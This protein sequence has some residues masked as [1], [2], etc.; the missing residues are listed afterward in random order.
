MG[1]R[2]QK[3]R[4]KDRHLMRRNQS[5]QALPQGKEGTSL[6]HRVDVGRDSGKDSG[7]RRQEWC[8]LLGGGTAGKSGAGF[9]VAA[10]VRHT[11]GRFVE[12]GCKGSS[13]LRTRGWSGMALVRKLNTTNKVTCVKSQGKTLCR[14]HLHAPGTSLVTQAVKRLPATQKTWLHPWVGKIP[15][16][17]K[18]H[19]TPAL[20]PGKS[21]GWRSLVGHSPWGRKELDTTERLHFHLSNTPKWPVS[22]TGKFSPA[23]QGPCSRSL[24]YFG[25]LL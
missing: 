20:S 10:Q 4:P 6:G 11:G 7:H 17:G 13:W 1:T 19:P 12:Q 5:L 22:E 9:W 15:W 2:S 16:R 24:A 14:N 21:H 25:F 8:R 23:R 18:W 3:G